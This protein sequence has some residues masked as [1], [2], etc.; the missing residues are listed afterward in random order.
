MNPAVVEVV[1]SRIRVIFHPGLGCGGAANFFF[2]L[3]P[4]TF[5]RLA[6]F[7]CTHSRTHTPG[8][9]AVKEVP[10][11]LL[12]SST[13][14][15]MNV[16]TCNEVNWGM[17][18]KNLFSPFRPAKY[19]QFIYLIFPH[20][21]VLVWIISIPPL[22]PPNTNEQEAPGFRS[23]ALKIVN[24]FSEAVACLSNENYP[25]ELE[26]VWARIGE[27]HNRRQIPQKAFNVRTT[28][29]GQP[30]V[31]FVSFIR[32]DEAVCLVCNGM[33][34]P[35]DTARR[36]KQFDFRPICLFVL[37]FFCAG[38]FSVGTT[39]GDPECLGRS[40]F[41]QWWRKNG[42]EHIHGHHLRNYHEQSR[43]K[44]SI[45]MSAGWMGGDDSNLFDFWKSFSFFQWVCVL[46]WKHFFPLE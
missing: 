42:L 22:P 37:R 46:F 38:A 32:S 28:L 21:F 17:A 10:F 4:A 8:V 19:L 36:F 2:P 43:R 25:A 40:M 30:F 15:Q 39:A 23:H 6:D 5:A 31:V 13:W 41:A 11:L 33:R 16:L 27:S 3:L 14:H 34:F 26:R 35:F 44:P 9:A 12:V 29:H 1:L 7:P 18:K 45:L 24:V 20:Y